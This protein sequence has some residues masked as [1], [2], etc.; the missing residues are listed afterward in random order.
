MF[1]PDQAVRLEC[2]SQT[3][4]S[5]PNT[6][7]RWRAYSEI[8]RTML[9]WTQSTGMM[10]DNDA[11]ENGECQYS[12]TGWII[13]NITSVHSRVE[14]YLYNPSLSNVEYKT[15]EEQRPQFY[16]TTSSFGQ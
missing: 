16:F 2:A 4:G 10:D 13:Y 6:E 8:S 15:P 12:R 9:S 1:L 3:I 11:V 14:C 7:F 5:D